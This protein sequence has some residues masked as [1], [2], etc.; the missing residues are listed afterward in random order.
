MTSPA[1]K[2]KLTHAAAHALLRVVLLLLFF[3]VPQ[4]VLDV[5]PD[6]HERSMRVP[7]HVCKWCLTQ[8]LERKQAL[9]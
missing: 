2:K 8:A 4:H 3:F 6:K 7:D 9:A 5:F 1:G